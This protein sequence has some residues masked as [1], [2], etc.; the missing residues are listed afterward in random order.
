VR[1]ALLAAG[2][3][4]ALTVARWEELSRGQVVWRFV[5]A[6]LAAPIAYVI[7]RIAER[8]AFRWRRLP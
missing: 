4:V 6:G 5:V 7:C 8:L 3:L 1:F 2:M